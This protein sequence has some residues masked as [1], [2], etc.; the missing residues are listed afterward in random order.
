V[1]AQFLVGEEQE[2][3]VFKVYNQVYSNLDSLP[4]GTQQPIVKPV[5]INDVPIVAITLFSAEHDAD[6]LRLAAQ[7]LKQGLREVPGT[8]SSVIVGGD[9]RQITIEMDP[10]R[11]AAFGIDPQM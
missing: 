9:G 4:A 3:S 11:S 5:D 1:T 6:A 2:D 10:V 8:S 7:Q